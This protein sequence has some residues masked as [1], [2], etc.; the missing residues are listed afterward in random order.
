MGRPR[1][2]EPVELID[3]YQIVKS[4][5]TEGTM[6]SKRFLRYA[7]GPHGFPPVRKQIGRRRLFDRAEVERFLFAHP[8]PS[9]SL[10]ASEAS[11]SLS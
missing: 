1:K 5:F 3:Q 2:I 9:P 7:R 11:I 6:T 10:A 4:Y 8:G